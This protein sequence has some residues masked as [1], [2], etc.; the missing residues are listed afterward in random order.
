MKRFWTITQPIIA[1]TQAIE[2]D[3]RYLDSVVYCRKRS[4]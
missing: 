4:R 2:P 3:F 1:T